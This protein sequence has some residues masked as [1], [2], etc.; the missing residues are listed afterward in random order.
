VTVTRRSVS[1][2]LKAVGLRLAF[3]GTALA[4]ALALAAGPAAAASNPGYNSIPATLP[5]N[6]ISV[7]F[8]ATST[9]E[10]GDLI[11]LGGT[12]RARADL[13]VTVVMSIWACQR[14]G[15][16]TCD[17]TPGAIFNQPL[18]LTIYNVNNAGAI[19]AA[20]TQVL[21]TT[22][23]F[24]LPYR[25]S[26]DAS[27]HCDASGFYPWY[28]VAE[29]HCYSGLAHEVTFI[30]PAGGDLP[31]ELIWSI[32]FNTNTH[33]YNP[34]G[35]S[36]PYDSLNV[37][38]QTFDGEPSFGTD[39]EPDGAFVNST[40]SGGYGDGGAAGMGT[41]RDD[42]GWSGY[43]PLACFGTSCQPA[44]PI[45]SVA[46]ETAGAPVSA[47]PTST[48]GSSDDNSGSPFA[49]LICGAF[50]AAGIAAIAA[51]RRTVRRRS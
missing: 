29:D 4:A 46:G 50:A 35:T 7:G 45:E 40:W 15:E 44:A 25:P 19:P 17:T 9:S 41:F 34:V 18:T 49:L 12:D 47:P 13:P 8:E 48:G 27:G 51:Q 32:A 11:T 5:G 24:D 1:S 14:G 23:T 43:R 6:V 21:Q 2:H 33:G 39:N 31:S 20:G 38:A 30:L 37:G 26:R 36:G 22:Q 3:A 10:F 42:T 16:A 28:S